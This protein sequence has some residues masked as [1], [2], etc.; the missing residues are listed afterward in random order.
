MSIRSSLIFNWIICFIVLFFI[1]IRESDI[2]KSLNSIKSRTPNNTPTHG[3]WCSLLVLDYSGT[4]KGLCCMM[5]KSSAIPK[6]LATQKLCRVQVP[7]LIKIRKSSLVVRKN[8]QTSERKPAPSGQPLCSLSHI[9][10]IP[11]KLKKRA[12]LSHLRGCFFDQQA[13]MYFDWLETLSASFIANKMLRG[14]CLRKL[15]IFVT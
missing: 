13:L 4:Y 3:N 5:N 1:F 9:S 2:T 11:K 15:C 14:L 7:A 10:V 6:R 12:V 8:R